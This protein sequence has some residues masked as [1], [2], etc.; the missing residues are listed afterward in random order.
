MTGHRG[1]GLN[2]HPVVVAIVV[3]A[4]LATTVPFLTGRA[5]LPAFFQSEIPVTREGPKGEN[6]RTP[7]DVGRE[8]PQ[9]NDTARPNSESA[10]EIPSLSSARDSTGS[11]P[12]AEPVEPAPVAQITPDVVAEEI[13][14]FGS[15]DEPLQEEPLQ[16]SPKRQARKALAGAFVE[17]YYVGEQSD[18]V[19]EVMS[20]LARL[21]ATVELHEI[22]AE[23]IGA[24]QGIRESPCWDP[25]GKELKSAVGS[26]K[27]VKVETSQDSCDLEPLRLFLVPARSGEQ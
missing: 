17:L 8:T 13:G 11:G 6:D 22:Y 1:S 2:D 24:T 21:G 23:E 25:V 27:D 14:N 3:I 10:R 16:L 15:R 12:P 26:F 9:T 18:D 7:E 20:R 4:A 5:S 19:M